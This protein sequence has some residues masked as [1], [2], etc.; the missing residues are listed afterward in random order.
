MYSV[1]QEWPSPAKCPSNP[2]RPASSPSPPPPDEC[3]NTCLSHQGCIPR[4]RGGLA[5]Q[6]APAL[7]LSPRSHYAASPAPPPP[8]ECSAT[9]L[10]H[11]G[12]N[13]RWPSA[14]K[15][16]SGGPL[17]ISHSRSSFHSYP[18]CPH[19]SL[20]RVVFRGAWV[21]KRR[22]VLQRAMGSTAVQDAPLAHQHQL[23]KHGEDGGAGLVDGRHDCVTLSRKILRMH[24]V[25]GLEGLG[26]WEVGGGEGGKGM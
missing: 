17:P 5:L 10:T 2:Y 19:S 15:C 26:V 7:C 8:P 6:R 1:G 23:I 18:N 9:P 22:K 21:A 16:S 20:T 25:G 14:A 4:G 3:R 24:G 11:Q 12:C 13:P